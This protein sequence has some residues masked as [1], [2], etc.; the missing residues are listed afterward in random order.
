MA[1]GRIS[2]AEG[3]YQMKIIF[4]IPQCGFV[5]HVRQVKDKINGENRL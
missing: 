1:D 2:G 4:K 5:K 3:W